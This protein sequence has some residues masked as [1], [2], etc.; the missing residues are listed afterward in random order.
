MEAANPR[1][2]T[3]AGAVWLPTSYCLRQERSETTKPAVCAKSE[4]A[5]SAAKF[6]GSEKITKKKTF[7]KIFGIF[8]ILKNIFG[9]FGKNIFLNLKRCF[10]N[11]KRC[12]LNLK[13]HFKFN[14]L[15]K[16]KF[17]KMFFKKQKF[18]K[19]FSEKKIAKKIF[20]TNLLNPNSRN[21]SIQFKHHCSEL[22]SNCCSSTCKLDEAVR[23]SLALP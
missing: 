3:G 4:T 1:S 5:R 7:S 23:A 21:R 13:R 17:P 16:P 2:E 10:L 18:P 20:G 11:L 8:R 14:F 12:F 22:R 6:S 9:F 19:M 15:K